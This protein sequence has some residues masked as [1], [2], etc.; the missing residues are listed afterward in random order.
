MYLHSA[1][2]K[3][4]EELEQMKRVERGK[5]IDSLLYDLLTTQSHINFG[6]D[7][8][9][10]IITDYLGAK[11]KFETDSKG[12][13]YINVLKKNKTPSK[14]MFS[15]HLDTVDSRNKGVERIIL[16]TEDDWIRCAIVKE[17]K[18]LT[19]GKEKVN[20]FQLESLARKKDMDFDTYTIR[21]GKVYGSDEPLFGNWVYT[22]ID[23]K[24][25]SEP[26][27]RANILGADDKVGCYIMCRMIEQGIPGMY[28]FHHGEEASC[29]GSK[30]IAREYKEFAKNF[31]YCIAFDRAGYNDI[32]TKQSGIV[33]CSNEF[34]TDLAEQMNRRLPPQEKM[35]PSPHGAY[36]DSASYTEIIPECT[37]ISVGY[38]SQHT[39]D[40]TFDHEWLTV[41]LLPALFQVDWESLPVSR[42]PSVRTYGYLGYGG[43]YGNYGYSAEDEEYGS[44]FTNKGGVWRKT[45]ATTASVTRTVKRGAKN[46]RSCFDRYKHVM[47]N[48]D[49]FDPETGFDDTETEEMKINRILLTFLSEEMSENEKAEL[50]LRAYEINPDD[51]EEFN[52][53]NRT[54]GL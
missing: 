7:A 9:R 52:F 17:E 26:K 23:A 19:I 25:K 36:T 44:G 21:D 8:V 12:N 28:V 51:V 20:K 29:Q 46:I 16:K 14:V 3:E 41:H 45:S 1:F 34:A 33:C 5:D 54:W 11:T 4:S 35:K 38:K 48:V 37:N 22:G 31:N 53:N 47:K 40:E 24:I 30:Y 39:D 10:K 42:D 2:K 49:P 18:Y 43:Y 50:V 6:E 32:I 15:S 27:L 13:L